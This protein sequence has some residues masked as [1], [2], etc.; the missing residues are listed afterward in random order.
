MVKYLVQAIAAVLL[1]VSSTSAHT[2]L[3]FD[4]L[5]K[6]FLT[7]SVTTTRVPSTDPRPVH[8]LVA[9]IEFGGTG[10]NAYDYNDAVEPGEIVRGVT[11]R[12][13]KRV[14][15]LGIIHQDL[16]GNP[17]TLENG[18]R[19]GGGEPQTLNLGPGEYFT[20][21]EAH[22]GEK[23]GRKGISFIKLTTNMNNSISGG[24]PTNDIGTETAKPGY[25]IGGFSGKSGD[26]IDSVAA[27]WASIKP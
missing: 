21:I 9:G 14:D 13:G 12:A 17:V 7:P 16:R 1:L 27:V 10:N 22:T 15:G 20:T 24:T 19:D 25:Q 2:Q 11:I 26:E 6:T 4:K 18:A 5:A 23:D 3:D 8:P